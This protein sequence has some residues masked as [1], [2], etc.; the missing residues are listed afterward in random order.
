[1]KRNYATPY[2]ILSV[3]TWGN[4]NH[5]IVTKYQSIFS[6]NIVDSFIACT[7]NCVI[8]NSKA[9][10]SILFK[11]VTVT[12]RDTVFEQAKN[13]PTNKPGV[14][15]FKPFTLFT[16]AASLQL[17]ILSL[18]QI[19]ILLPSMYNFVIPTINTNITYMFLLTCTP[20]RT[21]NDVKQIQ[22][23]LTM[24]ICIN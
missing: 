3:P 23:T 15:L 7:D 12:I 9:F 18:N 19:M 20:T 1:M 17:S 10:Y 24:Y 8:Q 16:V 22:Q 14:A 6:A 21:L 11:S 13:L 2:V 5:N 4:S